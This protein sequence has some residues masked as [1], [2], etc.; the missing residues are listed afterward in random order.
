MSRAVASASE[1]ESRSKVVVKVSGSKSLLRLGVKVVTVQ[2]SFQ[3]CNMEIGVCNQIKTPRGPIG[4]TYIT[5]ARGLLLIPYGISGVDFDVR[6]IDHR[7]RFVAL[8]DNR[9][10]LVFVTFCEKVTSA[11]SG[12]LDRIIRTKDLSNLSRVDLDL[13]GDHFDCDVVA[14][15]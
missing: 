1:I 9:N 8:S 3:N 5:P 4:M 6:Q 10:D 12:R 14:S 7:L 11:L 2:V 13:F 15:H